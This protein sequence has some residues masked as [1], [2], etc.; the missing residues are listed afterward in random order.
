MKWYAV[1]TQKYD[2]KQKMQW[3]FTPKNAI[4]YIADEIELW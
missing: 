3:V 4:Q 1:Q 2:A